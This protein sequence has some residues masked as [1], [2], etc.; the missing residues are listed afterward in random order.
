MEHNFWACEKVRIRKLVSLVFGFLLIGFLFGCGSSTDVLSKHTYTFEK[1]SYL[2]PLSSSTVDYL[3]QG[4]AGMKCTITADSFKLEAMPSSIQIE[5]PRYEKEALSY[6]DSPYPMVD[7]RSIL[8]KEVKH[9]YTILD[10]QG[11]KTYWR[12]YFSSKLLWV[13]QYN[14]N[15]ADGSEIIMSIYQYSR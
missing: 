3:S 14:D 15:T 5:T 11:R 7:I 1:V 12:L 2:S 4:M 13:A 6:S 10:Q 9:Q 8:S